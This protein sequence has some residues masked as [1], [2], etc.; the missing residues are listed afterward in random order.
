MPVSVQGT[1]PFCHDGFPAALA[2]AA[3]FSS[4]AVQT[5]GIAILLYEGCFGIERVA[6]LGAEEMAD[7]PGATTRN[8]NFRLNGRFARFTS[9]GEEFVKV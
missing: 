4:M 6:A 1:Y 2:L 8:D 5:P 7:V 9:R 3:E